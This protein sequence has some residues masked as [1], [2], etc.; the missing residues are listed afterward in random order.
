LRTMRK[1]VVSGY[2]RI[3]QKWIPVLRTEYAPV[4][5]VEHLL[6]TNRIPLGRKMLCAVRAGGSMASISR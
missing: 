3:P 6:A 2:A 4:I 5:N 1:I